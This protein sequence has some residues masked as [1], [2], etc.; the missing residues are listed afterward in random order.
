MHIR[1]IHKWLL[2]SCANLIFLPTLL[3]NTI[4]PK[5]YSN[6][7][8]SLHKSAG[9]C[10]C[11]EDGTVGPPGPSGGMGAVGPSGSIGP[12]GPNGGPTGPTGPMGPAGATGTTGPSGSITG[13]I[14]P[15][16]S[17][18]SAGPSTPVGLKGYAYAYILQS[19]SQTDPSVTPTNPN[20]TVPAQTAVT[21][22]VAIQ[23]TPSVITW[24][25]LTNTNTATL[26]DT[27]Y[28]EVIYGLTT[29][30]LFLNNSE[31][32]TD[33]EVP[34][35]FLLLLNGSN[36][37][38]SYIIWY[39]SFDGDPVNQTV[40]NNHYMSVIFPVTTANTTL[41]LFNNNLDMSVVLVTTSTSSEAFISPPTVGFITIKKLN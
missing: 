41:Q 19:R 9:C 16:G 33:D 38:P 37:N 15:T 17:T 7:S 13:P 1:K 10:N 31:T 5:P 26:I 2:F 32:G 24:S 3:A 21:F 36:L 25:S 34:A 40:T 18:G 4:Q 29:T 20:Q 8:D 35:A 30:A 28:Y 22:D 14:G 11:T 39:D 12:T 27:G 23:P 6:L